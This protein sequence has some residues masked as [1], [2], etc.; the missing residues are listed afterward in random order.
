MI[1]RVRVCVF[2]LVAL[3]ESFTIGDESRQIE[4]FSLRDYR[5]KVHSLQDYAGRPLVVVAFV[6]C[7]CPLARL[8]TPR[9]VSLAQNF[10]ERG[11]TFLAVNSNR[12][13]S[14]TEL[15]SYARTH[16]VQFPVLKDPDNR[17]AE[18]F[19]AT[20]TPEVFVLDRE[21]RIR[22]SG[23]IDNQYGVGTRKPE[24]TSDDLANALNDLLSGSP[25][26]AA[27][28]EPVGCFIGRMRKPDGTG[29]VSY[30]KQIARILQ[31][32][33]VECHRP[34]EIAPFPLT[35]YEEVAGWGET[36]GEVVD[37]G[38]MPPWFA[39]PDYGTFQ[40]DPRLS[41]EEKHLIATW[42]KDGCPEGDPLE[43]PKPREFV[44][45]WG[46]PRPPDEVLS[47]R[48]EPV[49][50]PAEG[51][52]DYQYYVVD[53]GWKED[54]W[55]CGSEARA[56]NRSVVHHILVFLKRPNAVY[57]PDLPGELISAYAPGM[58]P[59]LAGDRMGLFA[60]AGSQIVFQVHYTPNGTPQQDRSYVGLLFRDADEIDHEVFPGIAINLGFRIPA[61]ADNHKVQSMYV[62]RQ[63]SAILGVNPHMHYRGKSFRY[64]AFFPDG[65]SEIIMDCPKYDFNWQLGYNFAEP[66]T[67]PAGTKLICTAYFDNSENNPN[68]PDPSRALRFGEQTWDEMMIGWF[69][70]AAKRK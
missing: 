35:N 45:G 50:I 4:D 61:Y 23:R 34:G 52:V 53:P 7:E 33:C 19:G 9:L 12:Q 28:T 64:E 20:R 63:E 48:D 3:C 39:S 8:Y 25:V 40:H 22:Y 14:I 49:D 57:H 36:I 13:D 21:R 55:L 31:Q 29:D 5:G 70:Y 60:P 26:R 58:K 15:A 56:G 30:S 17:V 67:V 41:D 32:R 2:V 54:K 24:P 18:L 44:D 16:E 38:R 46:L 69:Y 6:G 47:M 59:T 10:S 1:G 66:R 51:V 27:R 11:V 37:S 68:N 62:F 43:L 42:V 65:T